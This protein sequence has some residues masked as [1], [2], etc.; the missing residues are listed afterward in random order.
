MEHD[1]IVL[2][3]VIFTHCFCHTEAA[4]GSYLKQ[5]W[6]LSSMGILY[7]QNISVCLDTLLGLHLYCSLTNAELYTTLF[8]IA[9]YRGGGD[10]QVW[11]F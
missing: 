4:I 11:P 5:K 1:K 6:S 2:H 8:D 9:F 3:P 7:I 10:M